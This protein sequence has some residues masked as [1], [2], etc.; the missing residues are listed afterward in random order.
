M[1]KAVGRWFKA[2]GYL[3]TGRVDAAREALDANPHVMRAKYD[4]VINQKIG[5][6][7]DYK[8]AVAAL[9]AQQHSKMGKVKSLTE[10]VSKL[11][12]L[13]TGAMAKAKKQVTELQNQGK[14]KEE[15]QQEEVYQ[16]C[17][18]AY[19]DFSSTLEE[20]QARI[21]ELEQ[22]LEQGEKRI[23][24]HKVQLQ[25]LARE[26]EK[27]KVESANAVAD[28]I[29]AHQE[30][31]IAD[32]LSGISQDGTAKELEDLRSTRQKAKAEAEISRD[33][34]GTDTKMQEA[35]FLEFA[36]DS[37]ASDEF[38]D[39]VG[40]GGQADEKSETPA[41]EEDAAEGTKLPEE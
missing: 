33:L 17:L 4:D 41:Q 36:Q 14:S 12:R 7:Q 19:R 1:F 9:M 35:E 38:E 2:L 16:K 8:K 37:E 40:L 32:A 39:L 18:S 34:A 22:D 24:E 3:L 5:Q 30:R 26:I 31:E 11:D 28:M 10:E 6:I 13:K 27:V 29:S 20:K 23:G 21:A 25:H 15:I